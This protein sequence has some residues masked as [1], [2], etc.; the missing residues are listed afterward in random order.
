LENWFKIE[1]IF[2]KNLHI[3]PSELDKMEFYR[4]EYMLKNYEDFIEEE[5]KQNAKQ[6]KEHEKQ[7]S[8]SKVG[9]S[10]Q[11]PPKMDVPKMTIPKMQMPKYK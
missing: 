6:N 7:I 9:H 1:F 11:K 8:T 5:N 3:I 10:N 2:A 4:V